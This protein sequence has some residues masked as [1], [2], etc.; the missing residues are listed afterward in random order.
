MHKIAA[1]HL[2][3]QHLAPKG[4][5]KGGWVRKVGKAWKKW[6]MGILGRNIKKFQ[7]PVPESCFPVVAKEG[8]DSGVWLFWCALWMC[9]ATTKSTPQRYW[10]PVERSGVLRV[11][12]QALLEKARPCCQRYTEEA[13]PFE[14][15]SQSMLWDL[16]HQSTTRRLPYAPLTSWR[17]LLVFV[18]Y[19]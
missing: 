2:D 13:G 7:K 6:Q 17:I 4:N 15:V 16:K 11:Q 18:S 5:G 19:S 9:P 12:R 8:V 14:A 1:L 10:E 3:I